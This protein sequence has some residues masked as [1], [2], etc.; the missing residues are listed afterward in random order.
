VVRWE[1][2]RLADIG[3]RPDRRS[4][5]RL[6]I[7]F[8]MGLILVALHT[9]MAWGAGHVRWV[10]ASGVGLLEATLTLIAF[11]LLSA[12]EEL[13]FHGYAL[14]R[15]WA[16]SSYWVALP[17]LAFVFALEHRVGGS[18]WGQALFG[19]GIGS[20][21]F[22][23]AA[24]ATRG[25]ALPIGL[26]AAWN[27]GDW[28]RGGKGSGGYWTAVVE[29]GFEETTMFKGMISYVLVMGLATLAFWWW[30]RHTGNKLAT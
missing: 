21:L 6:A 25:L 20:L 7:G 24:V 18:T 30:Y 8:L 19:A 16:L 12:R 13:A 29:D 15:L 26:H 22:G 5:L 1:G 3:V 27:F 4:A 11:L 14:R 28:I 10:P 23:M 17:V 2:L 9:V